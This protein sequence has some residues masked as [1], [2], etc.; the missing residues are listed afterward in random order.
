MSFSLLR[1]CVNIFYENKSVLSSP[2]LNLA[3]IIDIFDVPSKLR[4]RE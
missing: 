1:T 3:P 2:D 4:Q